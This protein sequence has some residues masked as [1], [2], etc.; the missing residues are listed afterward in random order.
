M[1]AAAGHKMFAMIKAVIFDLDGTLTR[2]FLNFKEIRD[3]IGVPFGRQSLLDQIGEMPEDEARKAHQILAARE[4]EAVENAE[5]NEGVRELV[6]YVNSRGLKSGVITRNSR[7]STEK[8]LEKLGLVFEVVIDR[9]SDYPIKPDPAP[10]MAMLADWGISP[11]EALMV[12]DFRY[13][14]ECGL[15]AGAKTCLVDNGRD[16]EDDGGPHFR[17]SFPGEVIGVIGKL[18]ADRRDG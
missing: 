11:P 17:V 7:E 1:P 18:D 15:A 8:T 5:I 2:P 9:E 12:G 10:L 16:I 3:E 14:V 6:E 4:R 13:D